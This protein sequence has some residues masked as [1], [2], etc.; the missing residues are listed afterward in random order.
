MEHREPDSAPEFNPDNVRGSPDPRTDGLERQV[1]LGLRHRRGALETCV[2][3]S[4]PSRVPASAARVLTIRR[5]SCEHVPV[6]LSLPRHLTD[7]VETIHQ[8]QVVN[9]G[10]FSPTLLLNLRMRSQT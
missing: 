5:I 9:H 1:I 10:F 8:R 4:D 6:D 7:L 2:D 3:R